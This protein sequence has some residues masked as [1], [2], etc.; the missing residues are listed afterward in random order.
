MRPTFALLVLLLMTVGCGTRA[1]EV[2]EPPTPSAPSEQPTAAPTAGTTPTKQQTARPSAAPDDRA[3]LEDGRHATYLTAI[4]VDGHTLTVDVI[5]FLTGKPAVDAYQRDHPDD[6]DGPPNDYY[7]V[8]ANPRL[9]T[10]AVAADVEVRLVRLH[11]GKGPDLEPGRW[12]ELPSYLANYRT[13]D[14]RLS[15]NPFWITVAA[16]RIIAIEEQYIP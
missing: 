9:R 7:I 12:Q 4:D 3:A 11:E 6:P 14:R 8:N 5:Q 2:V 13:D 1:A 10:L 16:G 15:N